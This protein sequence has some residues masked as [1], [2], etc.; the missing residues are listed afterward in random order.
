MN[1]P[2]EINAPQRKTA[3]SFRTQFQ[4]LPPKSEL[5]T[6]HGPHRVW[7]SPGGTQPVVRL[8][9]T[10]H[11]GMAA[12]KNKAETEI[13]TALLGEGTQKRTAAEV[14]ETLDSLGAFLGRTMT[15]DFTRFSLHCTHKGWREAFH[16]L[17][18]MILEPRFEE[19]IYHVHY[20][21]HFQDFQSQIERV[22]FIAANRAQKVL[23]GKHPYNNAIA[24][25]DFSHCHFKNMEQYHR[26]LLTWKPGFYLSGNLLPEMRETCQH[27]SNQFMGT[28]TPEIPQCPETTANFIRVK[29]KNAIQAALQWL[30]PVN[31]LLGIEE[32]AEIRFMLTLFGGYFGSR[33]M[34]NIREEK[35]LTYGIGAAMHLQKMGKHIRISTETGVEK[36]SLLIAEVHREMQILC[37]TP[38]PEHEV[39]IVK[40]YLA[41]SYLRSVDGAFM[42]SER[43]QSEIIHMLP[44]DSVERTLK[45]YSSMNP[46]KVS[47][48]ACKILI[49]EKFSIVQA[50][51][52]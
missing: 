51:G 33:L 18:E 37:S 9:I 22:S 29:K 13:F 48:T 14:N 5:F 40:N 16:L 42:R 25:K 52:E 17:S 6:N 46:Q 1:S 34:K 44:S 3:P 4:W 47:E 27:I 26:T 38:P 49:P 50:G 24:A 11:G 21:Q 36:V 20:N 39:E 19:S 7:V 12:F 30:Q 15:N 45:V 43:I 10:F 28:L 2:L 23:Y 32:L 31:P 35:G 8:D 41:G